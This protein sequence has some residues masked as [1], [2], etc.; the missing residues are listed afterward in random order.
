MIA[1][2][3]EVWPK[4]GRAEDYFDL[5]AALRPE[6]EKIDGFISVERFPLPFIRDMTSLRFFLLKT[7]AISEF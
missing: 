7:S 6:L 5:A 3:F 2:I 1:V 4:D